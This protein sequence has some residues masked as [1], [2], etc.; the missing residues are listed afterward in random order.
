[1]KLK[2]QN[3]QEIMY[4]HRWAYKLSFTVL[5]QRLNNSYYCSILKNILQTFETNFHKQLS[6]E[7]DQK[8][9]L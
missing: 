2:F 4:T 1:M 7:T 6:W 5:F 3:N 8:Q 9:Q